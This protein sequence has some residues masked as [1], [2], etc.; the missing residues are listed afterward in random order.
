MRLNHRWLF[1]S[2][3]MGLGLLLGCNANAQ[4][5][6]TG[7]LQ[8]QVTGLRNQT[9]NLCIKVF[10]GSRG[11]PNDN[12]NAVVRQC[13]AIANPEPS[14]SFTD[15]PSG[16][17]A[18]AIYHD[19]NSDEQLNRGDFGIPIEGYGFS[20]DAPAET[21]PA[22]FQDAMFVLGNS[23]TTMSIRMRYP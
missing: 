6:L 3:L 2:W 17:Y 16:N 9:G 4:I 12:D 10:S 11:F 22:E 18:I 21:G 8:V 5:E 13:T 15:L 20:N 7:D 23:Q 14:F 1:G 19:Q